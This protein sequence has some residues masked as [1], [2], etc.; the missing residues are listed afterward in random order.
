[1]RSWLT[2]PT[3]L[4]LGL[5]STAITVG[6]WLLCVAR[7][8]YRMSQD[9]DERKRASFWVGVI[10][11]A[12]VAVISPLTWS[13]IWAEAVKAGNHGWMGALYPVMVLGSGFVAAQNLLGDARGVFR[14]PVRVW[15]M[16]CFMLIGSLALAATMYFLHDRSGTP[17][18]SVGAVS[19]IPGVVIAMVV[20]LMV[21]RASRARGQATEAP[22]QQ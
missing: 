17:L 18:W 12:A 15:F 9:A 8:L 7:V 22:A 10:G 14:L 13:A 2:S 19:A 6:Q 21:S 11:L 20:A 16:L 5:L 1:M 4:L 3:V